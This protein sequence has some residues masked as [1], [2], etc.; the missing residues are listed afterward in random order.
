MARPH[1]ASPLKDKRKDKRKNQGE[2]EN[3]SSDVAQ[4][5]V[6]KSGRRSATLTAVFTRRRLL[7]K[8]DGSPRWRLWNFITEIGAAILKMQFSDEDMQDPRS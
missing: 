2:V 4:G 6:S 3:R 5:L 1:D 7:S 8:R